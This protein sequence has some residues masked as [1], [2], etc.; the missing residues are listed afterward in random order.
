[1]V[2]DPRF[3]RYRLVTFHGDDPYP[4]RSR[5]WVR[6]EGG[7]LG[8]ERFPGRVAVPGWFVTANPATDVRLDPLGRPGAVVDAATPAGILGLPLGSGRWRLAVEG[9]GPAPAVEV[10]VAAGGSL[11]FAPGETAFDLSGGPGAAVDVRLRAPP[12]SP[13]HVRRL[14]FERVGTGGG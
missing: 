8:I 9:S 6:A 3:G 2:L 4:F 12:A 14:V 10:G 5:V 1:M 11:A 7:K 13:L